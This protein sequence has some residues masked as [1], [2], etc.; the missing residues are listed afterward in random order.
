MAEIQNL[1]QGL[2]SEINRVQEIKLEYEKIP[3]G[4]LAAHLMGED[5]RK[6]MAAVGRGDIGSM[7]RYHNILK[8]YE[9]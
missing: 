4:K 7:A 8:Q 2:L 3:A 1:V 5:I 6:A 9:L